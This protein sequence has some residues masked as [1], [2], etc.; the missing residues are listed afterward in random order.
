MIMAKAPLKS[1]TESREQLQDDV[2]S[3]IQELRE[4][5]AALTQSLRDLGAKSAEEAKTKARHIA[6][7]ATTEA[8]QA[9]K[10]LR[11]QFG[12]LQSEVEGKVQSHPFAWLAGAVGLGVILGLFL[13]RRD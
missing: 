8:L 4:E 3:R 12:S 1:V 6:D 7:D 2:E 9:V 5:I 10:E 11:A 13:T